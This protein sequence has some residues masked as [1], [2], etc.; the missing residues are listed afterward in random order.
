MY[1][2]IYVCICYIHIFRKGCE[3]GRA[4]EPERDMQESE[5]NDEQSATADRSESH[6]PVSCR[7]LAGQCILSSSQEGRV[8]G[9][10]R[11]LCCSFARSSTQKPSCQEQH[12]HAVDAMRD[13]SVGL[14]VIDGQSR[15]H[16]CAATEVVLHNGFQFPAVPECILAPR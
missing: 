5:R 13:Q 4:R 3:T 8:R 9:K 15:P 11:T 10:T 12:Q 2:H 14:S 6:L 7:V 1:I 16:T